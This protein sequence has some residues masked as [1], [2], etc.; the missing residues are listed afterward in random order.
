MKPPTTVPISHVLWGGMTRLSNQ[1]LLEITGTGTP[2]HKLGPG[3]QAIVVAKR[4]A[5]DPL[6]LAILKAMVEERAGSEF[7]YMSFKRIAA[8]ANVPEGRVR[9]RV[10]HLARLGLTEYQNGL[11][12]EDGVPCG[13][14]YAAT[15]LGAAVVG[16]LSPDEP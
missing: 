6:K 5:K 9:R 7:Y 2:M 4:V 3:A 11:F 10:R 12:T 16:I 15:S 14:G 13:A 1:Q 8:E